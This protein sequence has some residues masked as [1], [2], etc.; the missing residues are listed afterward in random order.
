MG[1]VKYGANHLLLGGETVSIVNNK[2]ISHITS[3]TSPH[4]KDPTIGKRQETTENQRMQVTPRFRFQHNIT[5]DMTSAQCSVNACLQEI[6]PLSHEGA[7]NSALWS[8]FFICLHPWCTRIHSNP[9][10]THTDHKINWGLHVFRGEPR[11]K[12]FLL[13]EI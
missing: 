3:T 7:V 6:K 4:W 9:D 8:C 2:D 1:I 12:L 5:E 11:I 13:I 10:Y